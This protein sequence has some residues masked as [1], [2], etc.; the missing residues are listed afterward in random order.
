MASKYLT[1]PIQYLHECF[2]YNPETGDLTWKE[3]PREHIARE[4]VWRRINKLHAG[5]LAGAINNKGYY[6]VKICG[7]IYIVSR[8]VWAMHHGEWPKEF[9]D[10]INGD[11]KDNRIANLREA[12]HTENCCNRGMEKRNKVGL[13]GVIKEKK[14]SKYRASINQVYLGVFPTPELAHAA[15]CEAADLLHGKFSNHG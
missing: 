14:S 13:K 11:R 12:T 15:Y 10:H 6:I 1:L 5:N 2:L 9:I 4:F 3:R 7:K 8:I